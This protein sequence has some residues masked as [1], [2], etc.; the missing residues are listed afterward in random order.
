MAFKIF[1]KSA[2]C[3]A[4]SFLRCR[5]LSASDEAMIISVKGPRRPSSLNMRSVLHSPMPCAPYSRACRAAA[6]VSALALTPSCFAARAHS[7]MVLNSGVNSGLTVDRSPLYTEPSLP[8]IVIVSP[9]RTT[10]PPGN[11]HRALA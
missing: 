2:R 10:A 5:R 3:I 4:A 1:S 8:S 6:G 9:S 11:V 7:S